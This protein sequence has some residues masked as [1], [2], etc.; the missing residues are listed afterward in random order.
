MHVWKFFDGLKQDSSSNDL[1]MVQM[2][3]CTPNQPQRRI[4]REVNELIQRLV[5]GYQNS[6]IIGF[7]K[8]ISY[9]LS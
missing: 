4:Y 6:D 9:N 8:R 7:L 2:I 5:A 1:L 3:A